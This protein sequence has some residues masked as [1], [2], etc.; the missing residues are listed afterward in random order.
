[1]IS[2]ERAGEGAPEPCSA[3][4]TNDDL[5]F[6]G[7]L[8][9]GRAVMSMGV[10]GVQYRTGQQH[11]LQLQSRFHIFMSL[12]LVEYRVLRMVQMSLARNSQHLRG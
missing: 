6:G 10:H 5:Q 2:A 7:N 3:S 1:M 8:G 12:V 9:V 4:V 11:R